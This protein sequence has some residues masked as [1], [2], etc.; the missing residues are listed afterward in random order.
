MADPAPLNALDASGSPEVINYNVPDPISYNGHNYIE[1]LLPPEA[2]VVPTGATYGANNAGAGGVAVTS[3]P[4]SGGSPGAAATP[5]ISA[6]PAVVL[7]SPTS[8]PNSLLVSS[9]PHQLS[10]RLERLTI[11]EAAAI[12]G[13]GRKVI[14]YR[15][16]S[17]QLDYRVVDAPAHV[18]DASVRTAPFARPVT[19]GGP[20]DGGDG[21]VGALAVTMASPA[22]TSGPLRGSAQGVTVA[23]LGSVICR[24]IVG[25]PA[26]AIMV[27]DQKV[28]DAQVTG[29]T[30][31]AQITIRASGARTIK[32]VGTAQGQALDAQGNT[33][34][35]QSTASAL[36][37]V[38]LDPTNP[39]PSPVLPTV[40]ISSPQ[41]SL[42]VSPQGLTQVTVSGKVTHDPAPGV[43]VPQVTVTDVTANTTFNTNVAGDG[44]WSIQI[45]LRGLGTHRVTATC[46][47]SRGFQASPASVVLTLSDQQPFQRLKN[48]LLLVETFTLSSFLGTFGAG[49][50]LKTFTL[51]PGEE[52]QISIKS[53]TKT[54]SEQKMASSIVDSNAT[55]SASDFEDALSQE[56]N[57]ARSQTEAHNY[58]V[59]GS[60][61]VGW[62]FGSAS[63][64][65]SYS[66]SANAARQEAVK[67]V[68]NAVQKHSLKASTN[69]SVTVNTEYQVQ[70][71][72]GVEE[73]TTRTIKNINV[74]RALNMVFR[75]M[76][77]QHIILVHLTDVRVAW[78]AEDLMLDQ[79]GNPVYV[80][81]PVTQAKV[82][83]IR[84]RYQEATLPQ[85]GALLDGNVT[86]AL[87]QTVIDGIL[88][89]LSGI[90][91]YQGN[92][93]DVTEWVTPKDHTGAPVGGARYLR[94]NPLLRTTFTDS[95]SSFTVQVPGIVLAYEHLVMRTDCIM[96][97]AIL[98]PG[99]A[100]DR[101]SQQLQ[102]VTIQERLVEVQERQ[103]A[104]AR[105]QLA[106]HLVETKDDPGATIYAKVFPALP[107]RTEIELNGAQPA[108]PVKAG[109]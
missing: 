57:D 44:S 75:R 19:G 97:D 52:T 86:P 99:D 54:D 1:I 36:V 2:Y 88:N 71:E 60:A 51:L 106:R 30:Y 31:S 69:R 68:T 23:V 56:Q 29:S 33:I 9:A 45:P 22:S 89:A 6:P 41:S 72:Q 108:T 40:L 74:S 17:G 27:D 5:A 4:S 93:R 109:A 65:A 38:Q 48:R 55:D 11:A 18:L 77:Q 12:A 28:A 62:G 49:E 101:Y 66:G 85:L 3:A 21:Q 105:R 98:G 42:I 15:A 37:Q 39:N 20:G 100:L 8:D 58:S 46:M 96:A 10:D 79:Q 73:S 107:Q 7:A 61:S 32:A 50:T 13:T 25:L 63:L 91:D 92:L 90:P 76:N 81:D 103:E 64:S 84:P 82:L 34:P 83:D 102:D 53:Y 43:T 26:V 14:I 35:L 78:Y 47:D 70:Q 104:L 94:Y 59:S 24:N 67:N 16:I 95:D 80:T 87:H